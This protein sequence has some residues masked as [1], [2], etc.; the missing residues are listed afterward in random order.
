MEAQRASRHATM[1]WLGMG[2]FGLGLIGLIAAIAAV[3][4]TD[5]VWTTILLYVGATG[6]SLGTFGTHND[7]ALAYA[8]R[9]KR[10]DLS[11]PLKAE[12]EGEL[13][14]GKATVLALTATPGA[15]WFATVGALCLHGVGV[16]RLLGAVA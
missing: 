1:R 7:T 8:L 3:A 14:S 11:G 4:T 9:A 5:L 10:Q 2:L 15:A 16:W 12:L 6:F 13:K